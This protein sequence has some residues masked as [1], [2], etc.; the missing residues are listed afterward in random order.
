MSRE[1]QIKTIT[2]VIFLKYILFTHTQNK[3]RLLKKRHCIHLQKK[4]EFDSTNT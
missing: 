2:G 3:Q 4:G 1:N